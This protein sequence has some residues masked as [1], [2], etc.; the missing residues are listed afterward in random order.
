METLY[1]FRAVT[2]GTLNYEP[3][4]SACIHNERIRVFDSM[5]GSWQHMFS[6]PVL[7]QHRSTPVVVNKDLRQMQVVIPMFA[8]GYAPTC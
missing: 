2:S 4:F 8:A 3:N 5:P 1:L 6:N 7:C